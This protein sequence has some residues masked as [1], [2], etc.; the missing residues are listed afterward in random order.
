MGKPL[1]KEGDSGESPEENKSKRKRIRRR[2]RKEKAL[3][4][5]FF[6]NNVDGLSKKLESLEH[7]LLTENPSAVFL[8]ENKMGREGRIKT[9]TSK[10]KY[11]FYELHRTS[12]ALKGDRE[13][14]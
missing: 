4:L 6:G 1:K 9:P 10:K 7:L 12:S 13:E 2:G 8:Q 14:V 11:T 3:S 5:K